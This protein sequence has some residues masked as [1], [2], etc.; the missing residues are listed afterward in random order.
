MG[1][2]LVVMGSALVPQRNFGDFKSRNYLHRAS[3]W[4]RVAALGTVGC[5]FLDK[6]GA[7]VFQSGPGTTARYGSFNFA[8]SFLP[9]ML[10]LISVSTNHENV[11]NPG[12]KLPIIGVVLGFGVYWL[13]I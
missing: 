12:W 8:I 13:I 6:I 3:Y 5:T 1:S 9:C 2:I 4:M 10:L 7:E 11:Q